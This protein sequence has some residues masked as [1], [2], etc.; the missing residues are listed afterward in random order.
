MVAE[1]FESGKSVCSV[2]RK[3]G[4]MASQLFAWRRNARHRREAEPMELPSGSA[5]AGQAGSGDCRSSPAHT[6]E[7]SV[8]N[9]HFD[10]H[11]CCAGSEWCRCR[12]V[13]GSAAGVER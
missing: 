5:P 12:N 13:E 10:W 3:H 9:R 6:G 8:P 7:A 11:G 4:L 2:A 1:S